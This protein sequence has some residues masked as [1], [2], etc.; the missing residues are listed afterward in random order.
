METLLIIYL[1]G[2]L[3]MAFIFMISAKAAPAAFEKV[4]LSGMLLFIFLWPITSIQLFTM[5]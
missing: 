5:R 1:I 2:A 4:Q 3:V